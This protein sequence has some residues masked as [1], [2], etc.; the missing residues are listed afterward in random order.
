[1]KNY[2]QK[3][4]GLKFGLATVIV[5]ISV[6]VGC[7]ATDSRGERVFVRIG[8]AEVG[9][10]IARTDSARQLGLSGREYLAEDTGMLF[11]YENPGLHGIW[12]KDMNFPIDIIWIGAEDSRIGTLRVLDMK[13]NVSPETYPIVFTPSVPSTYVLEVNAGF[14]EEEGV[15]I[16]DSVT[17]NW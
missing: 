16:G 5:G 3:S 2:S 10:E 14:A 9:V 13:K 7:T 6:F 12:M 8:N 17:I 15:G 4:R 11:V 1:M